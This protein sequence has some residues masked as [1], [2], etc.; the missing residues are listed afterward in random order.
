[1]KK[2]YLIFSII[3][4][5]SGAHVVRNKSVIISAC[6]SPQEALAISGFLIEVPHCR[7]SKKIRDKPNL[8]ICQ[9]YKIG[10]NI[11]ICKNFPRNR[12]AKIYNQ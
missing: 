11:E 2:F 6:T 1:L 10:Q 4:T 12:F 3:F 9:E 8:K 5:N 7:F